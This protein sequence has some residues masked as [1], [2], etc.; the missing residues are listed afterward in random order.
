MSNISIWLTRTLSR[1][2]NLKR[3][4]VDVVERCVK[5]GLFA[6][7]DYST[8]YYRLNDQVYCSTSCYYKDDEDN[9]KTLGKRI[10]EG[11]E[12][13]VKI[14]KKIKKKK[15]NG[16]QKRNRRSK[17]KTRRSRRTV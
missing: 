16:K 14:E 7:Q 11:L 9:K 4:K 8:E 13:A 2:K 15:V 3:K 6:S 5:C 17:E 12:E 1:L 10:I